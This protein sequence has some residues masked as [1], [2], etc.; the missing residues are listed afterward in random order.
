VEDE[1]LELSA[2]LDVVEGSVLG[3]S[4]LPPPPPPPFFFF[5]SDLGV[6][7]QVLIPMILMHGKRMEGRSGKSILKWK[8]IPSRMWISILPQVGNLGIQRRIAAP[9]PPYLGHQMTGR[10]IDEVESLYFVV[11]HVLAV[12]SVL[13][14]RSVLIP[15]GVVSTIPP[16]SVPKVGAT[17]S[18]VVEVDDMG[19]GVIPGL[20]KGSVADVESQPGSQVNFVVGASSP[21]SRLDSEHLGNG[22]G[23]ALDES[24]TG[25]V[26]L[27]VSS[28]KAGILESGIGGRGNFVVEI[29]L[30]EI[31]LD[32]DAVG[33]EIRGSVDESL[34][35]SL[36]SLVFGNPIEDSEPDEEVMGSVFEPFG[37]GIGENMDEPRAGRVESLVF[38]SQPEDYWLDREPKGIVFTVETLGSQLDFRSGPFDNGNPKDPE[39]FNVE[40][41]VV[42]SKIGVRISL[43][44]LTGVEDDESIRS[45]V[46]RDTSGMEELGD[47]SLKPFRAELCVAEVSIPL[48]VRCDRWTRRRYA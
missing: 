1:V 12:I 44:E 38:G 41:V 23:E 40:T 47:P 11:N 46:G 26:G 19:M 16:V 31:G 30:P 34:T 7:L 2:L 17:S 22:I 15:D 45:D 36:D 37:S 43:P 28:D 25:R 42:D 27:L 10:T 9:L 33:S 21:G 13:V 48:M 4:S 6:L 39:D 29:G 32:L 3:S 5:P 14:K 18:A 24:G 35:E 8:E 20:A